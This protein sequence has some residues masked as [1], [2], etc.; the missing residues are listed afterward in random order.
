MKKEVEKERKASYDSDEDEMEIK[1]YM[2]EKNEDFDWLTMN[3]I[4]MDCI[5]SRY[6]NQKLLTWF[7]ILAPISQELFWAFL[8]QDRILQSDSAD[9]I[10]F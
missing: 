6:W 5:V 3:I 7:I 1:N 2:M 10:H 4:L 9:N 8:P